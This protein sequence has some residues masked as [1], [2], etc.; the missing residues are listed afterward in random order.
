MSLAS[1]YF[2]GVHGIVEQDKLKGVGLY[3]KAAEQGN[4]YAQFQLAVMYFTGVPGVVEQDRQKAFVLFTL[5]AEQGNARAQ[6]HLAGMYDT[7]ILEVV[8]QNKLKAFEL[9]SSAAEQ[10]DTSARH[11]RAKMCCQHIPEFNLPN[12]VEAIAVYDELSRDNYAPSMY[13]LGRI[14]YEGLYGE[15]KDVQQ[16]LVLLT[17]AANLGNS[18][19]QY[20]LATILA[21]EG[22]PNEEGQLIQ[23]FQVAHTLLVQAAE[24]NHPGAQLAMANKYINGDP[25]VENFEKNILK[26]CEMLSNATEQN[27]APALYETAIL[28][29]NNIL[30]TQ[31]PKELIRSAFDL[32]S[33]ATEQNHTQ[34]RCVL[35]SMYSNGIFDFLNV[36]KEK[37]SMLRCD[38]KEEEELTPQSEK[39]LCTLSEYNI[40]NVA[41]ELKKAKIFGCAKQESLSK[42]TNLDAL[43]SE[44]LAL[45]AAHSGDPNHA[46][47]ERNKIAA[48]VFRDNSQTLFSQRALGESLGAVNKASDCKRQQRRMVT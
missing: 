8:A 28:Y 31:E 34:A 48:R 46:P 33:K 19:A 38:I 32:L 16:G 15:D 41:A 11:E 18:D 9:Y 4:A 6:V 13:E 29:I 43:P 1:I 22:M 2:T 36:N 27:Y 23:N 17:N 10:G 45:I 47:I 21:N 44:M 37:A 5:A 20:M 40:K 3:I 35:A 30:E 26:A 12:Y 25:N 7:G 42:N 24:Q 39:A 14:H